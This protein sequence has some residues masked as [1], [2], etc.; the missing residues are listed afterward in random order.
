MNRQDCQFK[1]D[2]PQGLP[3]QMNEMMH[4]GSILLPTPT[5]VSE[6][7]HEVNFLLFITQHSFFKFISCLL[8][9]HDKLEILADQWRRLCL[10]RLQ[11][12]HDFIYRDTT[13]TFCYV[14]QVIVKRL[15]SF[16]RY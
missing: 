8:G 3:T 5:C 7:T 1:N 15:T 2:S 14:N 12:E 11:R 9:D 16:I 13:Y 10:I 4:V 6:S